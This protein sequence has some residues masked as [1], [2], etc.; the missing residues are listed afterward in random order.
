MDKKEIL[1]RKIA[2]I[3]IIAD[4]SD[5]RVGV[6]AL[7][8]S[9]ESMR[10]VH[11][12]VGD[13]PLRRF[14]PGFEGLLRIVVA[15]QVSAQSADAI[16][17]R[18]RTV[19]TPMTPATVLRLSADGFK[20]AGLSASKARTFAAVA[21]ALDSGALSLEA[22]QY[23]PEEEIVAA[24]TAVK[25]IGPWTAN[26]YTMFALGRADAW[27]SGD[28]AL[29]VAAQSAMRLRARPDARKLEM[30]SDRWRPW[31]GVAARLLWAWYALPAHRRR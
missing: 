10:R 14:E 18:T 2:P 13:P 4:V 25:G 31:R 17:R 19:V 21:G 5:I 6:R 11:D 9:C 30:I 28:L 29:Q 24:L 22:L 26:I 20:S 1:R 27:A 15:Q 7:R 3:R 16:W 12:T 23:A 8:R